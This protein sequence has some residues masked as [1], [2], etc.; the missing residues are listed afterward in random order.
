MNKKV[1]RK[2]LDMWMP[3]DLLKEIDEYQRE[4]MLPS[5]TAA[6]IQ[7]IRKGLSK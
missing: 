4:N 3:V 2:R 7:L 6:I 5:R 1:E